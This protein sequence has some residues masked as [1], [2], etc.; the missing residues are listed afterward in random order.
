[1]ADLEGPLAVIQSTA[2]TRICDNGGWTDTW[3][4]GHGQVFNVAVSPG[5]E[6]EIAVYPARDGESRVVI[7]AENFGGPYDMARP[8]LPWGPHP[9]IE[10]AIASMLLPLD[11]SLGVKVRSE[12]PPGAG[13]GTSAAVVVALIGALD[14]LTPGR[15]SAYEVATAARRVETDKLGRQSG[16]QDQLASA[17]GGINFIE[18]TAYPEA[19]VSRVVAHPSVLSEFERRL[20]LVYLGKSH[21][22]SAIHDQ[23]I[24]R[25]E[26][27]GP[28]SEAIAELRGTAARSRESLGRGDLE[29]LGRAMIENTEAQ[30]RLHPGLVGEG[31]RAVIEIAKAHGASGF[32]VNGAGGDGGSITLL[33]SEKPGDPS[34]LSRSI[35]QASSAF[36]TIPIR[37]SR[38]G[39]RVWRSE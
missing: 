20:L 12:A 30:A 5:A 25:L 31:A 37:L 10:A 8:G 39:L 19:V 36:R 16:V 1:M 26:E 28:D 13:T 18:V 14:A 7:H 22:S 29:G 33:C 35:E 3:F 2:P 32:K 6:V 34:V 11:L 27:Q 21:D 4:A 38:D 9:L 15:M 17:Y 23:V 24:R